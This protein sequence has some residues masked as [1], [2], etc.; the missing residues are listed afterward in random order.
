MTHHICRENSTY[1][2][3]Q[4]EV[5]II[6]SV[7][8]WLKPTRMRILVQT[9]HKI[10]RN[11]RKLKH[12]WHILAYLPTVQIGHPQIS[13]IW[14]S[15]LSKVDI[16]KLYLYIINLE[17]N[18][19]WVAIWWTQGC[20]N[21]SSQLVY[22]RPRFSIVIFLEKQFS[23]FFIELMRAKERSAEMPCLIE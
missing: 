1:Y 15:L 20:C 18:S 19:T 17:C 12:R 16:G 9:I 13:I 2:P 8:H 22:K 3:L 6:D 21:R 23:F 7:Y 11:L 5:Q 14:F 4:N 10:K